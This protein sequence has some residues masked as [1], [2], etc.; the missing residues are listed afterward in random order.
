MENRSSSEDE[1]PKFGSYQTT[2]FLDSGAFGDVYK[3]T[4]IKGNIYALKVSKLKINQTHAKPLEES[5]K[6]LAVK[7]MLK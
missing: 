4:D 5:F 2:K 7:K 1:L 6:V 3:A